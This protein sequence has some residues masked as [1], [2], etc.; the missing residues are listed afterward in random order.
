MD[1]KKVYKCC[2]FDL[3]GTLIN[4]I[5]AMTYSVNLT[6]KENNL[7]SI[8]DDNCKVFVGDGYKKLIERALI[9][10]GDKE[11]KYYDES[12]VLYQKYF[13]EHCLH[14]VK[15]YDGIKDMLSELKK[16]NIKIAVLSNKPHER[17]L[18]NVNAI[19][20]ENYFDKVYGE[21]ENVKIKPDPEGALLIAKE[22]GVSPEECLYF[23]DTNTDMKTGISAGMDTI[24]VAWGFRT[25]EELESYNPMKIINNPKEIIDI[26]S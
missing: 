1:C 16:R 4:S 15:A 14:G 25:I 11:L 17:T 26:I 13:K 23:G 7:G 10:C 24:G 8:D 19:F 9:Y 2:I 20:G 3:D 21:R 5:K 12:L 6:L 22:L 18:D